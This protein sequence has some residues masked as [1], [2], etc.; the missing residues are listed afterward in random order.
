MMLAGIVCAAGIYAS[1]ALAAHAARLSRKA[2]RFW[3]P[4]S[5]LSA[6]CT[7]WATHF[8]VLLAFKPGVPAAFDPRLTALSLLCAVVGIG[9]GMVL[10]QRERRRLRRFGAGLIVGAGIALL[11]YVGQAAY[12]VEGVVAWDWRLVSASVLLGVPMCGIALVAARHRRKWVRYAASPLLLGS[13]AVLHFCGMAAMTIRPIANRIL[14]AVTVSPDTI[15]PIVAA[16]SLGLLALA[17]VGMRFQVAALRRQRWERKRLGELASV[18]LEGLLICNGDR[19]VAANS[20]IER[21]VGKGPGELAGASLTMLLPGIDLMSMPEREERETDLAI[22]AANPVPVRVLR[23]EVRIG[24]TRQTVVAIRDQRERL[25]TEAKMRTLG[26]V[27]NSVY[28]RAVEHYA[29]MA[30]M[31]RSPNITA[32]W[33]FAMVHSRGGIFH[34][35]SDRFKIR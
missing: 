25:R 12:L 24:R 27:R 4:I 21:L 16:I 2:G 34:S 32:N 14:P 15:T 6:G 10:A 17:V 11:H 9:A 31:K 19:V 1:F 33:A 20:S 18:A 30:L 8:I 35:F 29:A 3:G 26:T 28:G 13:I 23:S 5:I 22:A 7:A